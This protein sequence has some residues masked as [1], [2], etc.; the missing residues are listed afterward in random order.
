M[1]YY[2]NQIAEY[3]HQYGGTHV[4]ICPGS[5]NAPL[6]LAFARHP[7]LNC[8]SIMDERSAA[9]IA[10]GMALSLK[11]PVAI[12]CTSGTATLNLYP[13]LAEA[14]YAD[15]PIVAITA[16]RPPELIDQWDGQAIRQRNVFS[17]H[18]NV[19][20]QI[21][22][23]WNEVSLKKFNYGLNHALSV[24]IKEK[25]PVH[26]NVPLREP[27]YPKDANPFEYSAAKHEIDIMK[28]TNNKEWMDLFNTYNQSERVLFIAGAGICEPE[29]QS[30]IRKIAG[31]KNLVLLTDI[32][33]G[34]HNDGNIQNYDLILNSQQQ[35]L[36][37]SLKPDLIITIGKSVVSKSLKTFLRNH[38]PN[39]HWH[40]SDTGVAGDPFQTNPIVLR[41]Q[42]NDFLNEIILK[43]AREN[44]QYYNTWKAS[45]EFVKNKI[46]L[47]MQSSGFS[48]LKVAKTIFDALPN[49]VVLHL[50]NSMPVRYASM[51]G[52]DKPIEVFGN[53]GT[54]GIDGCTSTAVGASLVSEKINVLITGDVA[55][56]YDVNAFLHNNTYSNLRV[57]V[58]N[59][60]G[61]GIF[62]VID[63]PSSQPELETFFETRH[64]FTC[65][66]IAAQYNLDYALAINFKE[67]TE[68]LSTFFVQAEK[69]KI[70]EVAID[71]YTSA[72]AYSEFKK[73]IKTN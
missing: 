11:K 25:T 17:N 8:I 68:H 51:L 52:L 53:R 62:R 69:A 60:G 47:F 65:R 70:L 19:S 2:I 32:V 7:S 27:L 20:F 15:V 28:P 46:Q 23:E 71:G 56:L 26:L 58:L 37:E 55:F 66:N 36:L 48:E 35:K 38:K 21:P 41:Y 57:I 9:Y 59:N 64:N 39:L 3:F 63:G 49:N 45:E 5:R 72:A 14:Y 31:E 43:S 33:S 73:Q 54:S 40:I 61:G 67:L 42:I 13:A 1:Q 34:Y 12:I 30:L 44:N 50:A 22:D 29:T 16:D 24:C 4:V 6:T 18:V 10:L